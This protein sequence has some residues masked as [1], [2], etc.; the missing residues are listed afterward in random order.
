M[1]CLSIGF[2]FLFLLS[3]AFLGNRKVRGELRCGGVG[4]RGRARFAGEVGALFE[5]SGVN[6]GFWD[7]TI[8]E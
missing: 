4:N 1:T 5:G 2:D 8:V 7:S 3:L 6:C